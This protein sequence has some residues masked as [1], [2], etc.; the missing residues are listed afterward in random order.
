MIIAHT[1]II[2][3]ERFDDAFKQFFSANQFVIFFF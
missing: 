2:Y 1:N 3:Y